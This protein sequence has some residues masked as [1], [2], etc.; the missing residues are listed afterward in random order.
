MSK[1]TLE[2]LITL[3]LKFIENNENDN[4]IIKFFI[5]IN[6]LLNFDEKERLLNQT[7]VQNN[8][9]I[10]HFS[11]KLKDKILDTLL[12]CRIKNKNN[13]LFYLSCTT[14][15]FYYNSTFEQHPVSNSNNNTLKDINYLLSSIINKTNAIITC[16]FKYNLIILVALFN[17]REILKYS[18]DDIIMK[19]IYIS[20]LLGNVKDYKKI[21]DCFKN[22]TTVFNTIIDTIKIPTL[23]RKFHHFYYYLS[24]IVCLYYMS[25]LKEIKNKAKLYNSIISFLEQEHSFCIYPII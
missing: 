21:N 19:Y 23:S 8:D 5:G 4:L 16:D 10:F 25:Y 9:T 20:F 24:D 14:L 7:H 17:L 15:F 11:P 18:E 13:D 22:Y 6:Y 12:K 3:Y 1:T 2:R